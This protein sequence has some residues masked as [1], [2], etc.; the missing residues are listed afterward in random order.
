MEI[1]EKKN[2]RTGDGKKNLRKGDG[3]KDLR[4][5]DAKKISV[6]EMKKKETASAKEI[7]TSVKEHT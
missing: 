6:K 2:L 4:K 3:K 7:H 5:G 1:G